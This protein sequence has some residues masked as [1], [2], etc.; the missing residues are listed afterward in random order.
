MRKS[1]IQPVLLIEPKVSDMGGYFFVKFE[2]FI[3]KKNAQKVKKLTFPR[4][5]TFCVAVI[6][7]K[8]LTI[9]SI[10]PKKSGLLG[11][12]SGNIKKIQKTAM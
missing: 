10:E 5:I 9:I 3:I 11:Y 12:F 6:A 2:K 1:F 7:G 4:T 8:H